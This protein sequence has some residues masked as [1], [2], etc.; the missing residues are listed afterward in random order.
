MKASIISTNII[1]IFRQGN[2]SLF[3]ETFSYSWGV[4][5][6]AGAVVVVVVVFNQRPK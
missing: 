1:P 3:M 4:C 5:V 2:S 6:V